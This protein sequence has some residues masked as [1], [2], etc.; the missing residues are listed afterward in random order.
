M[1]QLIFAS[2]SS[3]TTGHFLLN[4]EGANLIDGQLVFR[5][6][7]RGS[8]L[9]AM[10]LS[11]SFDPSP[12]AMPTVSAASGPGAPGAGHASA[13]LG[14]FHLTRPNLFEHIVPTGDIKRRLTL[15]TS[16]A[17][18]EKEK[19]F[20]VLV[21]VVLVWFVVSPP[22]FLVFVILVCLIRVWLR[23]V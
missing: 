10:R 3:E 19:R 12:S 14:L 17:F 4:H 13:L 2:S 5:W 16:G 1:F 22:R 7:P 8:F 23:L 6:Q 20:W 21:F 9:R 11:P 15:S 18:L